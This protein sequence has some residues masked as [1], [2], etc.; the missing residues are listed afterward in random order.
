MCRLQIFKTKL[1]KDGHISRY[2]VVCSFTATWFPVASELLQ[3]KAEHVQQGYLDIHSKGKL[4]RLYIPKTLRSEAADWL[5][6]NK[7]SILVISFPT[8][9]AKESPLAAGTATQT[10][11]KEIWH[12]Q[13]EVHPHSFRHRF[14]KNFLDRFNDLAL[15]V[16][17]GSRKHRDHA[18]SSALYR[19][20]TMS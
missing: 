20:R 16:D 12:Q 6:K 18:Y 15:L 2:F 17:H 3:I 11:C 19:D 9:L 10:V 5:K 1:K 14:A 8:V 7:V 13:S 4:R